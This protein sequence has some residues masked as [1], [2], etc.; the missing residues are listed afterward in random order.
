MNPIRRVDRIDE[1]V[2]R[3]DR[4]HVESNRKLIEDAR[5]IE[6]QGGWHVDRF[7]L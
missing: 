6:R 1:N 4:V 7:Y 3:L 5:I 2:R